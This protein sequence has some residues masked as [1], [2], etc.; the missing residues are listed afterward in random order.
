DLERETRSR[1]SASLRISIPWPV[2]AGH[3]IQPHGILLELQIP[4]PLGVGVAQVDRAGVDPPATFGEREYRPAVRAGGVGHR[5][6][7]AVSGEAPHDAI[8]APIGGA[9]PRP[10]SATQSDHWGQEL[11]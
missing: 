5:V 9:F 8:I 7:Q 2:A 4:V 6:G 3:W 1:A 10:H 11:R